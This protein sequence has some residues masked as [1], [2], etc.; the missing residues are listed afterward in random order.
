M[1]VR[2]AVV[3]F[4]SDFDQQVVEIRKIYA[5]LEEKSAKA[6]PPISS[7]LVE[8]IGYW[9]HKLYLSGATSRVFRF[10]INDYASNR[11]FSSAVI[12]LH[13]L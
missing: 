1:G 6:H 12:S 7:E 9:L 13:T 8:S 2:E 5:L 10:Q 3:L 4:L 11:N